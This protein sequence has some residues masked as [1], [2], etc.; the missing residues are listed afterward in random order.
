MYASIEAPANIMVG[1]G[2]QS[3]TPGALISHC[4]HRETSWTGAHWGRG[5]SQRS[6]L[7]TPPSEFCPAAMAASSSSTAKPVVKKVP[8]WSD[9]NY[10]I[11]HNFV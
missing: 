5:R 11:F 2:A 8:K 10:F 9:Y 6:L 7:H 1:A 4:D 3:A